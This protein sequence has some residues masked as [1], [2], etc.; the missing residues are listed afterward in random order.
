MVII[1]SSLKCFCP[2]RSLTVRYTVKNRC[3]YLHWQLDRPW[4]TLSMCLSI[5]NILHAVITFLN[6]LLSYKLR[7]FSLI[8]RKGW[9]KLLQSSLSGDAS[10]KFLF[11][12]MSLLFSTCIL[13]TTTSTSNRWH[14]VQDPNQGTW[15]SCVWYMY[16][17]SSQLNVIGQ[18]GNAAFIEN[19]TSKTS[20][21]S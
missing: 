6:F 11:L 18:V 2:C 4:R 19:N 21:L 20:L 13:D 9:R 8:L 3:P 17:W 1:L 7:D 12:S 5:Q 16:L 14:C 10:R 15:N